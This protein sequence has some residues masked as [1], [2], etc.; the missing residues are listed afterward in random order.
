MSPKLIA[1]SQQCNSL[2]KNIKASILPYPV[3]S[4]CCTSYLGTVIG[5]LLIFGIAFMLRTDTN[6]YHEATNNTWL[7]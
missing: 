3:Q 5:I 1:F 7:Y 2:K 6:L 4:L